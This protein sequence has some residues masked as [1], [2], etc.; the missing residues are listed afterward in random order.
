MLQEKLRSPETA[1]TSIELQK[2]R[3]RV[4]C[5]EGIYQPATRPPEGAPPVRS[6]R[7]A[8]APD[9]DPRRM[10]VCEHCRAPHRAGRQQHHLRR[11]PALRQKASNIAVAEPGSESQGCGLDVPC[12]A[13]VNVVRRIVR[14]CTPIAW[15]GQHGRRGLEIFCAKEMQSKYQQFHGTQWKLYNRGHRC[16]VVPTHL[17]YGASTWAVCPTCSEMVDGRWL[18]HHLWQAHASRVPEEPEGISI[19]AVSGGLMSLGKRR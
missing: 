2:V 10:V 1:L 4:R 14:L 3:Q 13:T 16:P 17:H 11:C 5:G 6:T 9:S 15:V 12:L 7:Q 19:R 18:R 8:K